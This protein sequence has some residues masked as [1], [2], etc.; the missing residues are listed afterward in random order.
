[1]ADNNQHEQRVP[2]FACPQCG[3]FITTSITELLSATYLQCPF[4]HLQLHIDRRQSSNALKA[5][6]EVEAA[7]LNVEK[8]S[9]FNR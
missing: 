1:M 3:R 7:R 8:K 4:C 6:A 5:L 9:K 2:G